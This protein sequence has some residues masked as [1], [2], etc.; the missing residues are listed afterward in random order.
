[1][2]ET[3]PAVAAIRAVIADLADIPD[4][5]TRARA[6]GAVLDAV[7]GLQAEIRSARQSAVAEMRQAMTL[8]E[9]ADALGISGPRVSQIVSGIS[10]NAKK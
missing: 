3:S 1:M 7:P 2:T 6:L 5:T 4:P 8:A 10:R 9:A